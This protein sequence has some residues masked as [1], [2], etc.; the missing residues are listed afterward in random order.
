MGTDKRGQYTRGGGR[1][2][3]KFSLVALHYNKTRSVQ[4]LPE[5]CNGHKM[6]GSFYCTTFIRK[7]FHPSKHLNK[8]SSERT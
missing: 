1:Q 8:M 4:Y 2:E 5:K 7:T 3:G 6:R